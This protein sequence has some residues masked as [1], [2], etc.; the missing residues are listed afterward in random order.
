MYRDLEAFFDILSQLTNV[1]C[2]I[3]APVNDEDA[4][5]VVIYVFS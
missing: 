4:F 1:D 3:V 5:S 2:T